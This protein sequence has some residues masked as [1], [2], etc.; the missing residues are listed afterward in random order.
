MP[1][2]YAT[3]DVPGVP[4]EDT[5]TYSLFSVAPPPVEKKKA[6]TIVPPARMTAPGSAA[7]SASVTG[8]SRLMPR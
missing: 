1:R 7:I 3:R 6:L 2:R 8:R 4:L 5:K